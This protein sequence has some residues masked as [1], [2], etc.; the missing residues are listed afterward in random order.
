MA[1]LLGSIVAGGVKG[2]ADNRA[3]DLRREE[4]FNLELALQD[5]AAEKQLKLK[6]AGI[7]MEEKQL[8]SRKDKVSSIANSVSDPMG[9]KGGYESEEDSDKRKRGLL[10]SKADALADAGELDAAKVYYGRADAQD[11]S[12]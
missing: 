5:A 1:G 9:G 12:D 7:E 11:K 4:S 10:S 6:Q 3:S 8:Q 2:Y